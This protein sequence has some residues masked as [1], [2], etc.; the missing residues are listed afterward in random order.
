[1][2]FR[3]EYPFGNDELA[4]MARTLTYT[5]THFAQGP[6]TKFRTKQASKEMLSSSRCF[7]RF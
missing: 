6:I 4:L 2:V 7:R 1:M 5:L 3:V